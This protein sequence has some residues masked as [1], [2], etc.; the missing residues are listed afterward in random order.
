MSLVLRIFATVLLAGALLPQPP[1][2]AIAPDSRAIALGTARAL[3]GAPY[4]RGGTG[5]KAFDCSGLVQYAY[6]KAGKYLP[7]TA[8]G[9]FHA[10]LPV[11]LRQ[12]RPGDLVFF[13]K[14][15]TVSHVGLYAGRNVIW[16]APRPGEHVRPDRLWTRHVA[17]HTVP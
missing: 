14:D 15:G 11:V 12:R 1:V 8:A 13:F 5:P 6:K 4:R 16:H 17:Y 7:R 3:T 10:T 2:Q 9:Q